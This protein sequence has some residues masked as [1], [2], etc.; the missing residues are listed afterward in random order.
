MI[1]SCKTIE[2]DSKND[3]EGISND[4]KQHVNIAKSNNQFGF[5]LLSVLNKDNDD[6]IFI[7]PY[8][9]FIALSLVVN[10]SDGETKEEILKALHTNL[11]LEQLNEQNRKLFQNLNLQD[12]EIQL[13]IANSVWL[14]ENYQFQ[15]Q[16]RQN[17]KDYYE[18]EM[19]EINV[20]SP[21]TPKR[22]NEWVRKNTKGKIDNI[23]DS[24]LNR[25]TLSVLINAIYFK[26]KWMHEFDTNLT[27]NRTFYVMNKTTKEIPFMKQKN[28][29]L[30][31]ENEMFQA[32][33]LP[34][35][36]GNVSMKVLL[37]KEKD[38]N[39]FIKN[40][41]AENWKK[42][43]TKFSVKEGTVLLP[44]FQLKYEIDLVNPL[45]QLGI[46]SAFEK[47]KAN[48]SK[49]VDNEMG[50]VWIDKVKQITYVDINEEGTEA[51]AATSV[52]M[53]TEAFM[54]HEPFYMEVNRPFLVAIVD[55]KTDVIL[56][57][58][59]IANP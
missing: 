7:S 53:V 42:W 28:N 3:I 23:L 33:S 48:F 49:L 25:D 44:K 2:Q 30:Y 54:E 51:A 57:M 37:P 22:I 5:Q 20:T 6:N 36:D 29:W 43:Q 11:Q 9:L 31:Y 15:K 35:Q 27:E 19:E 14:N 46:K 32:I 8:S 59:L 50:P 24:P 56:F 17:M 1:S 45:K 55:D 21:E 4:K 10:G 39:S 40:M 18:A 16:F 38:L 58:G 26:G 13:N 12:E 52:V 47:E 41:T 34:Y